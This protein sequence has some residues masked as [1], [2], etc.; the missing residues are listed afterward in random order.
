MPKAQHPKAASFVRQ[1]LFA[2]VTSFT[3]LEARIAALPD[4]QTRGHAFEVFTEACLATQ[5]IYQAREVW[6]GNSLPS[7][8][9]QQLRLPT[10]DMGVDGIFVTA[11]DEAVCYQSKFRTGRPSLEW[12]GAFHVLWFG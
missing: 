3:E 11:A 1:N 2:G 6:P 9:R 12:D 5:R 10:T 4:E 7:M 8:L